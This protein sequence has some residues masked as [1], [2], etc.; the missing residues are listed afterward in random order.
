V[1][2]VIQRAVSSHLV[3]DVPVGVFLSGGVDSSLVTALASREQPIEAFA[4]GTRSPLDESRHA[5]DVA[6]HLGI[7]LHLRWVHGNDFRDRFEQWSYFNDDPVSDPSALALMLLSEHA[8]SH[9]MKVMLAGEGAD[10]L[11]G[12]YATY[13]VVSAFDRL[14]RLGRLGAAIGRRSPR[15]GGLRIIDDYARELPRVRFFG[16][17]HVL[18]A[19]DRRSLLLDAD[20]QSVEEWERRAFWDCGGAQPARSAMLFDQL[21]R[22]PD[23][24]LSR[25]DRATMA[26]S[27]EARVPYLDRSVVELANRLADEECISLVP[28]RTK[29]LLKRLAAA[30]VPRTAVYRKKRGFNLP[31]EQWLIE[32]FREVVE[33]F[34]AARRIEALNYNFVT[35]LYR[36]HVDG[37]HRAALLWAWLVLEQW[38]ESWIAGRP[39]TVD[40]PQIV[41]RQSYELLRD[42]V[43]ASV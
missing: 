26:Y 28:P 4:I 16:S 5:Q 18:T 20:V 23:D 12:G 11:F 2:E 24:L 22:L 32:D 1:S 3:A 19:E 15:R 8:R 7:S 29:M 14:A 33:G 41:D 36:R 40:P 25:T 17:S 38:H 35:S 21:T 34:L 43:A 10:E 31:V 37:E 30:N 39:P 9:G 27:L 6:D 42:S 13:Q